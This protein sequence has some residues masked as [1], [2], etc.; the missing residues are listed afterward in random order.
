[1]DVKIEPSWKEKLEEEFEQS[2]F[3]ELINFLKQERKEG[4]IIYPSGSR[5]FAA[6][7]CTPF[8]KVKVV[9]LGQDPYHGE[10][11]AN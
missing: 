6:F 7:D 1:M 11:H 4:K 5:I 3:L 2:Y 9:L 8:T 10:G